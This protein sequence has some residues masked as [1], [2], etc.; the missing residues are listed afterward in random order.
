MNH[1]TLWATRLAAAT[2]LPD[3]RLN[4]RMGIILDDFADWPTDSVPQAA[5]AWGQAKATYRFLGNDRFTQ[6]DL[7]DGLARDTARGT[8][9]HDVILVVQDTTSVNLTANHAIESLGPID[10]KGLARGLLLHTTLAIS[11]EG[12]VLGVLDQQIWTRPRRGEPRPQE[13]ESAKWIHGIDHAREALFGV[14]ERPP[15]LIHVMDR[16]G[17]AYEVMQWI[18]DLGDGAIIRCAQDRRVASPLGTA[19][20]AVR[21]QPVLDSRW[22]EVPRSHGCTTRTAWVELRVLQ[23]ELK[24]DLSKSPH[25]WAMGWTLIEV[26]EPHPPEGVTGLHWLLWTREPATTAAEA[27][28][29]VRTYTHRWP[30]EEFHLTLKSGCRIEELRLEEWSSLTKALVLYSA[31]AARIVGLRDRSRQ[32]AKSRACPESCVKERERVLPSLLSLR[33]LTHGCDPQGSG[34]QAGSRNGR[35]G[36]HS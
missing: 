4:H 35:A 19:H 23:T 32:E 33:R 8:L 31:V 29:V 34:R 2:R 24:P 5:G 7:T 26:W 9:D 6:A 28:E 30:I 16:E 15:R 18:D 14:T 21:D 11:T 10:S 25:G 27:W 22:Q 1:R 20:A 36:H 12:A 3:L 17:D 13:K